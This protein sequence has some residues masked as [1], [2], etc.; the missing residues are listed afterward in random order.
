MLRRTLRSASLCDLTG[1][2]RV[3][4]PHDAAVIKILTSLYFDMLEVKSRADAK[5]EAWKKK[6]EVVV[7]ACT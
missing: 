2:P 4:D 5:V 6:Y 1:G 3:Q 7:E